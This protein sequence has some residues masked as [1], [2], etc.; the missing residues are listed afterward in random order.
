MKRT[1]QVSA[2]EA[3]TW[4]EANPNETIRD[5]FGGYVSLY[6]WDAVSAWKYGPYTITEEIPD[7][8]DHFKQREELERW[9][10]TKQIAAPSFERGPLYEVI[11]EREDEVRHVESEND[12]LLIRNQYLK[13]E[14]EKLKAEKQYYEGF[15]K[16]KGYQWKN[17]AESIAQ[18]YHW[19]P[20]RPIGSRGASALAYREHNN[21]WKMSAGT[22]MFTIPDPENWEFLE[23]EE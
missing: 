19:L 15:G 21:E 16:K 2:A 22:G 11:R 14:L 12:R 1:R 23:L 3:R 10:R 17:C 8:P 7:E 18:R 5:R 20:L 13:D 9:M 4:L 6:I